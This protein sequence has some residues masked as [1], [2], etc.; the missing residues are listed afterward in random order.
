MKKVVFFTLLLLG[1]VSLSA[2]STKL[3]L[4]GKMLLHEMQDSKSSMDRIAEDYHFVWS[5]G[6]RCVLSFARVNEGVDD[7]ALSEYGVQRISTVKDMSTVL[8]P[9]ARFEEVVKSGVFSYVGL[10]AEHYPM[11]DKARAELGIDYI[12]QGINLP[13]GYDGTGVVVGVIDVGFEYGHPS[14]YDTTGNTLRVKRVWAQRDNVGEPPAGFNFGSEYTTPEAILAAGRDL[15]NEGHG[16]HVAGMAAGCGAPDGNGRRYRGMAPNADI[17]MVG[18]T[19]NDEGIF[20]G[21]RYIHQYA[22]S[23]GKPCVINMSLGTIIGPHDGQD[24]LDVQME[25]YLH[26]SHLDSIVCVVSA[27]NDGSDRYHLHHHFTASDTVVRSFLSDYSTGDFSDVSIYVGNPGDTFSVQLALYNYD[28]FSVDTV[29]LPVMSCV[30]TMISCQIVTRE[31]SVYNCM[32]AMNSSGVYNQRP[33]IMMSIVKQGR[34]GSRDLFEVTIR[35][36]SADVHA[37]DNNSSFDAQGDS[38]HVGGD[39]QY[40]IGGVGANTNAVISAGSYATRTKRVRADGT[41]GSLALTEE[42]NLSSFSSRGPSTLGVVKPDICSPGQYIV[43]AINTP[44]LPDYPSSY[45]FDSTVFNGETHYYVLMQGTSMASPAT[46]GVVALWLQHS[47]SLNVDSVRAILHGSGRKDRFTGNITAAGDNNWGWGKIDAFAGLPATT[48]PLYYLTA[49]PSNYSL[50]YV[51]GGGRHPQGQHIVEAF[52]A[53]GYGFVQWSDG[54][55]DNP[56]VIDLA[57]DTVLEAQF[58]GLSC[59]TI[60]QY[61]WVAVLESDEL[62]C[63]DIFSSDPRLTWIPVEGQMMSVVTGDEIDNWLITPHLIPGNMTHL[64]YVSRGSNNDS[65][66]IRIIDENYDT[67]L[68]SDVNVVAGAPVERTVSL[69]AYAGQVVRVA[70]HHHASSGRGAVA[71]SSIKLEEHEGI[72]KVDAAGY[73]VTTDGL[74]LT[75]S[76]AEGRLDIY[77]VIGRHVLSAPSANG[78]FT[79]PAPGVYNLRVGQA[80]AR[81]V[82][83][84]R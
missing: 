28:D 72:E 41:I 2:Q 64:V 65:L 39:N 63:W 17:V 73:Q 4:R 24:V 35:S 18:T 43:S 1:A 3:S 12:H 14:F 37:W 77:D 22:R 59:D 69:A 60:V 38:L 21:I 42:G 51:V 33:A 79:M 61:P 30:D 74:R 76:A 44:Y 40:T 84:M 10:G 6:E 52:P 20:E 32:F 46:T 48:V 66:A 25:N 45:L 16:S 53:T 55:T 62:R 50:G 9:A 26:A 8:I 5:N 80:P 23:V 67:V 81:K 58:A 7:K 78:T 54:V 57:G 70:F 27:G 83:L 75:L 71:I 11:L 82:V 47:A 36:H 19:M 49:M 56:R 68:L 31:D 34:R 15:D 13:Q 29:L